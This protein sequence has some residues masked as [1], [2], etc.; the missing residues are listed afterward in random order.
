[1]ILAMRVAV[2]AAGQIFDTGLA[3][4]L[5]TFAVAN[6]VA[7]STGMRTPLFDVSV[8]GVRRVARTGH[9]FSLSIARARPDAPPDVAVVPALSAI[10]PPT[11]EAALAGRE[12]TET[13]AVLQAWAVKRTMIAAACTGKFVVAEAGL[14]DGRPA[15]TTWWLGPFFRQR[16][17]DVHLDESRM[18]VEA[19]RRVTAGA[20]LAHVD[21][22]LWI[23]GRRSPPLAN[24]TRRYLLSDPR[25]SQASFSVPEHVAQADP[26]T[27]RFARWA[28]TH[29]EDGFSLSAAARGAGASERTLSRRVQAVL[30]KSPLAYFQDLRVERAVQLL[31][32]TDASIDEVA[33]QVGYAD[34]VT[35]RALLRRR[36]GRGVREIRHIPSRFRA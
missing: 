8:A 11:L 35:L 3:T 36:L 25:L 24:L 15:T 12:V 4:V 26:V 21:L 34:G 7:A 9:G 2:L 29:L 33:N 5:D 6:F 27:A 31:Q 10:T 17:P 32:T 16:Y 14:L 19:P 23:V 13:G 1:M 22:A 18:I 30:G 20:A 28:R